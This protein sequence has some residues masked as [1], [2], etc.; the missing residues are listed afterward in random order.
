MHYQKK[1]RVRISK[2]ADAFPNGGR[3][4]VIDT[5]GDVCLVK[6]DGYVYPQKVKAEHLSPIEQRGAGPLHPA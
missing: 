5:S 4:T 6:C 1:D 3:G 2:D